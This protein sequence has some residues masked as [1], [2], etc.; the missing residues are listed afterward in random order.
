[1]LL[2]CAVCGGGGQEWTMLFAWLSA[3]FQLLPPLPTSKLGPSG[4]DSQVGGFVYVLGPCGS[5]QQTLLWGWEFVLLPQPPQIFTV[6]GLESLF[7]LAG[8]LGCV[9]CLAPQFFLP[10]YLHANV[11]PLDLPATLLPDL[12]LQP[13]C[14]LGS[15]PLRLPVS[16]PPT[17]LGECFFFNFLFV[18]L[19]H[20]SI[21]SQFLLFFVFKFVFDLLLVVQGD[22]VYLDMPPSWP[23]VLNIVLLMAVGEMVSKLLVVLWCE[24]LK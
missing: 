10:V 17:G 7:P 4:V 9:I 5:L 11:G 18:G 8:A 16:L 14:S 23:E 3:G 6:G 24:D 20:S 19:P 15:S 13:P 21:F 1:M 12:V 22:K 2:G